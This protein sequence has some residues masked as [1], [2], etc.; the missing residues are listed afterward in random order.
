MLTGS[1]LRFVDQVVNWS[2]VCAGII[3]YTH[4]SQKIER[5][6]ST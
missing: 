1:E 5:N 3:L 2:V 4:A 6:V